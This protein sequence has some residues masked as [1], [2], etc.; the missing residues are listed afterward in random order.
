VTRDQ[1]GR[2]AN[3]DQATGTLTAGLWTVW[4]QIP[5]W[6]LGVIASFTARDLPEDCARSPIAVRRM[7]LLQHFL[8]PAFN[9]DCLVAKVVEVGKDIE[10]F[11]ESRQVR[12]LDQCPEETKE[13]LCGPYN[14]RLEAV[15]L[16]TF[17]E[18]R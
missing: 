9:P 3:R 2:V 18:K 5:V 1:S 14:D 16:C 15:A 7:M 6:L 17:A 13:L 12:P 4:H 10:R 11:D 8:H